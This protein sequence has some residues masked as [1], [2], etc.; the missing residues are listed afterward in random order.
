MKC[1]FVGKIKP[2]WTMKLET[3]VKAYTN[4]KLLRSGQ[5]QKIYDNISLTKGDNMK[6]QYPG[7]LHNH[8]HISNL[9]LRDSINREEE[10]IDY[11]IEL[12]HSVIA[13]TEHEALCNTVKIEKYAEK[14]KDK[15]K[16]IRGNEIYLCRNGLNAET[17]IGG[18]DKYWHFIL[19]AKD[20]KG[21]EQIREISSR[22]WYRSYN[23]RNMIRVPTYYSDLEEIIGKEPGHVIGSTACLGGFLPSKILQ[24]LKTPED[25]ELYVNIQGWCRNMQDIF[26]RNDFYLEM[27]PSFNKEQIVVNNQLT[28]LSSE[29]GIPYIISTDSHYLRRE[30]RPIHK[31][32]LTSQNGEREVDEFYASTYMM[33]TEELESYFEYFDDSVL[34]QAYATIEEIRDKCE[35]FSLRRPLHIPV[36]SWQPAR[37]TSIPA[38]SVWFERMPMMRTF[39]SSSFDGDRLLVEKIID[40]LEDD[41]RL[42]TQEV[43]DELNSNLDIT[44]R[45]SE[46][47]NTHWSAYFLNLQN[48]I[49]VC[50]EAGT[51]VGCGRGSGVG[52]LLLYILNVTQINPLWEETKCFAWRFLNPE[53]VSVLDVDVDIEG[54]RRAQVLQTLRNHYGEDRVANVITFGTEG[55]K[56]SIQTAARG[57]GIDID[58]AYYLSS[59][60]P[61]DRG[62]PRTLKQCYYGDKEKGF[63]PVKAMVEAF[64]GDY[65]ELWEVAQRIEGLTC[66]MGIHAGGVV[67]V[68]EPFTKSTSLMKAPSGDIVTAFELHDCEECSQHQA[69]KRLIA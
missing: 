68:D 60:V 67:F 42:Q 25:C 39:Y 23:S 17:F 65:K 5:T 29:L 26:G 56:A 8:S 50:W 38:D 19:L 45:S 47:N 40:K 52:F 22:A 63:K 18:Q 16:V 58:E 57:L 31:A 49:D 33:G 1:T 3:V 12:G 30:D 27:Q 4:A 37:T 10:L 59:L 61:V 48:I 9:R 69:T 66:R 35:D 34:Q 15:I 20:A 44:W 32:Y 11:A 6:L 55:T 54:G 7:S 51:L 24:W 14:V 13:F 64:D 21:H 53:R 36:L 41:P 43:Y 46:V 62:K 2:L 28:T